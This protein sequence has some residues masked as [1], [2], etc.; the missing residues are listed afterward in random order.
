MPT[1]KLQPGADLGTA[2]GLYALLGGLCA[3]LRNLKRRVDTS[4]MDGNPA[5]LGYRP[6]QMR[7]LGEVLGHC[8]SE[9]IRK[10]AGLGAAGTLG[11]ESNL[12]SREPCE[13]FD[14]AG[15]MV[16][17]RGC[18]RRLCAALNEARRVPDEAT[19]ALLSDLALRLERQ[20]WLMDRRPKNDE[21]EYGRVV[22]LFLAC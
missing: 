16:E 6:R 13:E 4:R 14:L 3:D 9:I 2:G 1:V 21:I 20:L 17:Y 5:D 8:R 15:F 19:S 11:D 7:A 22:S 12:N 10:V 18:C